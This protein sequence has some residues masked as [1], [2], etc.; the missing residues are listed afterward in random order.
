[1]HKFVRLAAGAVVAAIVDLRPESPTAGDWL[2]F[3]LEP[4]DGLFVS[5]GLGNAFQSVSDQPSQYLYDFS[6]EWAPGLPGQAV[7]PLDPDLDIPWPIKV[8]LGMIVSAKDLANPS[9]KEV[10]GR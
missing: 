9:L 7:H 6:L 5:A 10:L 2:A 3:W 1:M 4:G 8:G